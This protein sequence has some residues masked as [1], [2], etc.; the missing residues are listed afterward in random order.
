MAS[1][2][3]LK[4][5]KVTALFAGIGGVELGLAR[6]GHETLLLCEWDPCAQSVL[7]H[8]F[9]SI[10]LVGDV[11]DLSQLPKETELLT[12]GFPCQDLSQAG[13]TV[14]ITGG[15]SGLVDEVFRL[16]EKHETP[17]VLLE[18]VP[19]M[20]QLDKGAAMRHITSRLE[21]LGYS[22]A[23]RVLDS[24]SFG[25]PQRRQRVFLIASRLMNP[26]ELL[27]QDDKGDAGPTDHRGRACGFYWTEGVRGLGWAID[28]IPT[29]KGGS[30][31]G[32]PSPPA[33]WFP[34]GMIATP[35]IR[36][37]ERLQGFPADWTLPAAVHGNR[38]TRWK[39]V[40]NAVT[41]N[42]AEW[43]GS[44]LS[45]MPRPINSIPLP[46]D[47]FRAWPKAAYGGPGKGSYEIEVSMFPIHEK[48]PSLESFLKFP[49]VP[50]SHRAVSG[51]TSRLRSGGLNYPPEF[52]DDL[53]RH[54]DKMCTSSQA[55]TAA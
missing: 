39:L 9:E 37:A 14:G 15:R 13:K 36:D 29:L 47:I 28:A 4:N 40:G 30:T 16:L 2:V 11:R 20:L 32:I 21:G 46:F 27:F 1:A 55:I 12:A 17:H 49:P 3:S 48:R 33:I 7:Q 50:L 23:Y 52:L 42:A 45:K 5:L 22:W 34:N 41:V 18:N 53:L 44:C 10:P 25:L 31:I 6:S 54:K 24:R 38:N 26:E 43:I 8:H 19:F 35:D 51:F